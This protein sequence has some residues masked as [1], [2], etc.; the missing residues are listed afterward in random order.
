MSFS[1]ASVAPGTP[2]DTSADGAGLLM[3]RVLDS[4]VHLRKSRTHALGGENY[5]S[6]SA[7][8]VAVFTFQDPIVFCS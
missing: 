2:T 5:F 4:R 7:L 6:L 8:A 3:A 1:F